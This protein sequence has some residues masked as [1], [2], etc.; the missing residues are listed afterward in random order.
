MKKYKIVTLGCRTNQY[1]SQALS[2]QLKEKGY[3][4]AQPD[5][6]AEL[7]I[8]N[9]CSVTESADKRSLY[10]IRKLARENTPEKL[11]VTGCYAVKL[12]GIPGIT[13]VIPN[14]DK[15]SLLPL[16]FPEEEWP[17]F[18]IQQ[19]DAHT[20]AFVKIQ[21]GCDSFCSYCVIPFVRG[22]SR[23]KKVTDILSEVAGLVEN[24]YKEVVLTGINIGDFG[25]D[26]TPEM[27]LADLVR[28]VD[29]IEGL[30]RIRISSID[31]DE[32]DDELIEVVLSGK[33]TCPSMH[34]VLQAGSNLT[35]KRM[36]RKYTKQDFLEVTAKLLKRDPDFTFT[37]DVIVGFPGET[38]E[39]FQETL[40]LVEEMQFAKVHV[41]PYSDRPKTR[42]S[43]MEN[44]VPEKVIKERKQRLLEAAERGAFLLRNRFV[45][46]E[47]EVL[48]ETKD[49]GHTEHFLPVS[50]PM[51]G[52]RPNMMVYVK[53]LENQRDEL[54]GHCENQTDRKVQTLF[55]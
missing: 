53:C 12:K 8:V 4:K 39:D 25:K 36:R 27:S 31:P 22:R 10:Q 50:I 46:R 30:K 26:Q 20:R 9:T 19:F 33:K 41:F 32:V 11:I 1:E 14:L 49:Q 51:E 54:V 29:Q 13:H 24:G 43:R 7:C 15:E 40:D 21:D 28:Q 52:L 18:R 34:I 48:T 47:L 16:V 23:S 6:K 44:K 3:R 35:L 55:A 37:T 5:E 38:E 17:E 2:D 45:G 42:A